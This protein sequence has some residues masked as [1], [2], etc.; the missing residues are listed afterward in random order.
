MNLNRRTLLKTTVAGAAT[1]AYGR[2][3][4]GQTNE[5]IKI[6]VVTGLSGPGEPAGRS[7][8]L[9]AEIAVAQ[10]NKAGGVLG[11]QLVLEFRDD[12]GNVAQATAMAR[13][14]LGSGINLLTGTSQSAVALALG[15]VMQQEGGVM[16]GSIASTDKINH[17][18]FNAHYI[19]ASESP[20]VRFNGLA[21]VAA[22][23]NPEITTWSGIIPDYEYGH[24]SWAMFVDGLLKSYD[25]LGK[26]VTIV[27]PIVAPFGTADY[28]TFISSSL[29]NQF[30][31]FFM[32]A[33]G[34]DSI[35]FY[36]QARPYGFLNRVKAIFDGGNEFVV[37]RALKKNTPAYWSCTY[38]Y[39]ENNK[40]IAKNTELLADYQ[41]AGGRMP[42]EGIVAE[43]HADVLLLA[44]AIS[45]AKSTE[46]PAIL[47]AMKG[48]QWETANGKRTIRAEDNQSIRDPEYTLVAAAD[49]EDGF[50]VTDFVKLPGAD[51]AEPATPGKAL[52]LRKPA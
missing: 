50:A 39:P 43:G 33:F 6:G 11:R 16:V 38:W 12:K 13:E 45:V 35:T 48:L 8:K 44:Q 30:D 7:I 28:K 27:D 18:N 37:S 49:N 20:L 2:Y 26:K 32:G 5:P 40:E 34:N 10:V 36:Q 9:G 46:T 14:L 29:R 15:P 3:A 4:V 41:A 22:L 24:A 19:R 31:G 17:Q 52:E 42:P 23:K 1:V 21:K 47:Q 51:L 25:E